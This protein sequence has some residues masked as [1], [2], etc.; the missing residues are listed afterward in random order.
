MV[1][2]VLFSHLVSPVQKCLPDDGRDVCI[3]QVRI[4]SENF[5]EQK[6]L[7]PPF[8]TRDS[9]GAKKENDQRCKYWWPSPWVSHLF[10]QWVSF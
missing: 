10:Q 7:P 2:Q 3:V 9:Y 5:I 8:H 1:L 6:S 4:G